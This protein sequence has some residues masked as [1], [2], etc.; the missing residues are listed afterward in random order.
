M[1]NVRPVQELNVTEGTDMATLAEWP[2]GKY[3]HIS[4]SQMSIEMRTAILK[5]CCSV[6]YCCRVF[7]KYNGI[8]DVH[9]SLLDFSFAENCSK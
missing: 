5:M 9:G 1:V 7:H 2:S 8:I 3:D 4:I 6:Q